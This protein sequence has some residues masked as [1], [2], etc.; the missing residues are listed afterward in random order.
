MLMLERQRQWA[1]SLEGHFIF[2]SG[3][4]SPQAGLEFF[5]VIEDRVRRADAALL[6]EATIEARLEFQTSA[7][8]ESN[9]KIISNYCGVHFLNYC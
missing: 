8:D 2:L 9:H 5:V 6:P 1:E 4:S 7:R 3:D